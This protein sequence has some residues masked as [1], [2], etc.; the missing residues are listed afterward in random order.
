MEETEELHWY[1]PASWLQW[2]TDEVKALG[3][4]FWD[5][6]LGGL[7]AVIN[8]IPMPSW[9]H[10]AGNLLGGIPSGVSYFLGFFEFAFGLSVIGSAYLVRFLIR[11]IPIIG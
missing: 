6:L 7:G 4:W 8:A 10:D 11:R 1:D 3:V 9:A 2:L 5:Q